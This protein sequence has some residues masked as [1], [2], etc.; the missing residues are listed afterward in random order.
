MPGTGALDRPALGLHASHGTS[1]EVFHERPGTLAELL[2]VLQFLLQQ[3]ELKICMDLLVALR[4]FQPLACTPL[5]VGNVSVKGTIGSFLEEQRHN[6]N[7]KTLD[8]LEASYLPGTH[9]RW[10]KTTRGAKTVV[11]NSEIAP[12]VVAN[13]VPRSVDMKN[14]KTVSGCEPTSRPL[15]PL[16]LS[17]AVVETAMEPQ[18]RE[19]PDS[20]TASPKRSPQ[21]FTV[22]PE[23]LTGDG[24]DATSEATEEKDGLTV[25]VPH[26]MPEVISDKEDIPGK[27]Y[28]PLRASLA[29]GPDDNLDMKATTTDYGTGS[30]TASMLD[31]D[32]K[33]QDELATPSGWWIVHPNTPMRLRWD[34]IGVVLIMVEAFLVPLD[35]GFDIS[36]SVG[37]FWL[38]TAYFFFDLC[39]QFTTGYYHHG[40]LVMRQSAIIS[41]YLKGFFLVDVMA[42]LPWDYIFEDDSA[43]GKVAGAGKFMRMFRL[44]RVLRLRDLMDRIE[45]LLPGANAL[46]LFSLMKMLMLFIVICHWIACIWGFLGLPEKTGHA[47]GGSRPI[48]WEECEFGGPCESGIEGSPWLRRHGLDNFGPGTRYLISL[49]FSAGLILGAEWAVSP[50]FWV[51]RIFCILMMIFSFFLCS[52][53]LSRIVVIANELS[54]SNKELEQ[55]IRC[56]KAFMRA[57]KVPVSLQAKVRQYLEYKHTIVTEQQQQ[58]RQF[59]DSLSQWLRLEILEHVHSPTILHN[60]FFQELPRPVLQ[61]VCDLCVTVLCAHHDIVVHQGHRATGMMYIVQGHLGVMNQE[62]YDDEPAFMTAPSWIGYLCLFKD[63][64]WPHAV[65]SAGNSELLKLEKSELLELFAD[66]PASLKLYNQYQE[67]VKQGNLV[68]AGAK[69][70][71]CDGFGHAAGCC[72]MDASAVPNKSKLKK[73]LTTVNKSKVGVFSAIN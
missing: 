46:L 30:V 39:S 43:I 17:N 33:K 72:T 70:S 65:V 54:E 28:E 50:G 67:L 34:L 47:A 10:Q 59:M 25:P 45:D 49:Q 8:V 32:Q 58:N 62:S 3:H 6:P 9:K 35:L 31:L 26:L 27:E 37:W 1:D 29:Q 66:F 5:D 18:T 7:Q 56:M 14:R 15:K 21:E 22:E 20:A 40:C 19:A 64:I 38:T 55:Q 69:C 44:L 60:P 2:E 51:E 68:E 36:A 48:P 24:Q 42:T 16:K 57:K 11:G 23:D 73:A 4:L 71:V 13:P 41:N 61:R 12:D 53:V 63:M 52:M